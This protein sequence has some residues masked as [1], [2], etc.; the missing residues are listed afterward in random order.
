MRIPKL[1][2]RDRARFLK[3]IW[4]D[5]RTPWYAKAVLAATLAYALSPIDLIPDFIPVLGYLDDVAIVP[6]GLWLVYKLVPR[7]VW[8]E[9]KREFEAG[10][11][12]QQEEE[13]ETPN[14]DGRPAK[15]LRGDF[16]SAPGEQ[17]GKDGSGQRPA[18]NA[19]R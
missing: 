7:E 14:K 11:S 2:I 1:R 4:K 10:A 9:H 6:L 8:E 17:K 15:G 18:R 19:E 5:P 3:A 16:G 13:Q 12:G